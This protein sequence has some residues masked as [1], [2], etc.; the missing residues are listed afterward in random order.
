MSLDELVLT[1]IQCVWAF[2]AFAGV[3]SL[4]GILTWAERKQA[5]LIQDRIGPNRA[6]VRIIRNWR[7]FGIFHP[8]AD[9]TKMLFKEDF[10]PEGAWRWM[11][12]I[13]PILSLG[14][15]FVV[16]AVVPFAGPLTI[17]WKDIPAESIPLLGRLFPGDVLHFSNFTI[18]F[19]ASDLNVGLLFVLAMGGLLVYGVM[20]GGFSS[21]NKWSFLGAVRAVN[22]MFSYEVALG[23]SLIGVVMMYGSTSLSTIVER[24]GDLWLGIIPK[25]GIITQ[26]IAF[27]LFFACGLMEI[28]RTP[29]DIPE[30]ESEIIAGYFLEYSGAKFLMFMFSEY[31]E[32][33]LLG[34]MSAVLFFGG[35]QIPWVDAE[36]IRIP[37]LHINIIWAN[38]EWVKQASW[39]MD[40][41]NLLIVLAQGGFFALKVIFFCWLLITIRW[42]WPRFRYDQIMRLGWKRIL[43][44]AM[45]NIVLT[46]VIILLE[47]RFKPALE[48]LLGY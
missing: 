21:N 44:L 25:W 20:M 5:S 42:T 33:I 10:I 27:F 43:P 26:P 8:I 28:K 1:L 45:A 7:L 13:A 6:N 16:F 23:L 18:T 35:W 15:A 9:A 12:T 41:I 36:G 40:L 48:K 24:Q 19:Q 39:R 3:A 31:V 46:I 38:L 47:Q 30:G 29:F 2:L 22:Q 4:A 37:L 11:H 32:L 14:L 17:H 34:A